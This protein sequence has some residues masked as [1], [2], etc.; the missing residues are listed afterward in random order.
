MVDMHK[1][2]KRY[3]YDPFTNGSNSIKYVL[4]AILNSSPYLQ[5]KYSQPVYGNPDFIPSHNFRNW[6]WIV[7]EEG[8]IKDPYKLLP[9]IFDD[10]DLEK[11]E[12]LISDEELREGGAAMTAYAR[13]QF[14]EMT[15]YEREK[16]RKAL[17]KYCELDTLAMV[18]IYEGWKEMIKQLT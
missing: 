11:L 18:M 15:E 10:T 6:V 16:V 1:M 13:M 2:V 5:G 9:P 8:K 17:L 12:L 14:S 7:T 4:P 3:Y